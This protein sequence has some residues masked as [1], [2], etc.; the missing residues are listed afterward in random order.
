MDS[1]RTP[2]KPTHE[3]PGPL[4]E[5]RVPLD[6]LACRR[7][8]RQVPKNIQA[9]VIR[10]WQGGAGRASTEHV[11]AMASAIDWMRP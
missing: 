4:C 7:H 3:C 2:R 10:A 8:W 9:Q 11:V 5:A 1:E 6:Q